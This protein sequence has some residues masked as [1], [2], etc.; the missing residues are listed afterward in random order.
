[1]FAS[2]SSD[3]TFLSQGTYSLEIVDANGCIAAVEILTVPFEGVSG[4]LEIPTGF[5]PN[6]DGIHDEWIVYGLFNFNN[7]IVKV[8]NRW[9]QEVFSSKGYDIP[10]DG[11]Y[12]NVDL[13]T[14]AYY[15]VIEIDD[16]DKVFN[17][18]VTIK[19]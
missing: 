19:R 13:H 18:T 9:G 10:W 8:Y 15:Y 2:S 4:C 14:A 6:G 7:V 11:K 12:D 17:G 1:M 5:T 16:I 3:L